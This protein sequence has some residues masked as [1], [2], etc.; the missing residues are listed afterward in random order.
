MAST[1][2]AALFYAENLGPV[3]PVWPIDRT[4]K[5][6]ERSG[7]VDKEAS[8]GIRCR[9]GND[10]CRSIGK[11]PIT[12]Y[13]SKPVCPRGVLDASRSSDQIEAWW[14]LVPDANIGVVGKEFFALDVDDEDG[15]FDL[16]SR[17]GPL[18]DTIE[19]ISGSGGRHILF[20]QPKNDVFG[21]EEGDLPDGINV[22]GSHGYIIVAP[23]SHKSGGTYEWELSSHPRDVELAEA[24]EWLI[25]LIGE[26]TKKAKIQ[27]IEAA[28]SAPDVQKLDISSGIRD[29][30]TSGPVDGEDRSRNDQRTIVALLSSGC[31]RSEVKAIFSTYPIGTQGKYADQGDTYL[32]RSIARAHLYVGKVSKKK[33]ESVIIP[34]KQVTEQEHTMETT[35]LNI[36]YLQ[37]WH[38][39]LSGKSSLVGKLWPNHL[40]VEDASITLYGLGMRTDFKVD[41][42]EQEFAALVVP[43]RNDGEVANV[44]YDVSNPP[45]GTIKKV[46]QSRSKSHVF[47]TDIDGSK[48]TGSVLVTEDWDTAVYTYLKHGHQFKW[49]DILGMPRVGISPEERKAYMQ[50]L[51]RLLANSERIL[52]AWP[53][54]RRKEGLLLANILDRG[55]ER[56]FEMVLPATVKEMYTKYGMRSLH[57]NRYIQQATPIL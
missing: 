3:V 21:N 16:V 14:R 55:S 7:G 45:P 36:A 20:K 6:H 24:P 22:R 51:A 9:C 5:E 29:L 35:A 40:G 43:Y 41:D 34:G 56:V 39:A 11:H 47:D 18:P 17:Y 50:A 38:D 10:A 1:K 19:S 52:L 27:E 33:K 46:W 53:A 32:D 37:G 8:D 15:L 12:K 23:S 42:T 4:T 54:S 57:L 2:K 25:K 49:L 44:C 48:C 26:P 31:T 28:S 30:I 13:H